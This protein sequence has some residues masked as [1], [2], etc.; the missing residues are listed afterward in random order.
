[1]ADTKMTAGIRFNDPVAKYMRFEIDILEMRLDVY[2]TA[3]VDGR[4][5]T[6]RGIIARS[7]WIPV[8]ED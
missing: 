2:I 6:F 3:V 8:E 1:M 5:I 7:Q 4:E